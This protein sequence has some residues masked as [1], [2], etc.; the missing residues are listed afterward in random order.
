MKY[1]ECTINV[2]NILNTMNIINITNIINIISLVG[3][4]KENIISN[5]KKIKSNL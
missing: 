2:F 5:M 1:L 4:I 3:I